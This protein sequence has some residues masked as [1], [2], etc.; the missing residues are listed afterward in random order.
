MISIP[1]YTKILALGSPYTE[2]ALI[3]DVIVQEKVDGSQ[4]KFGINENKEPVFASKGAKICPYIEENELTNIQKL[5]QPAVEYLLSI[6]NRFYNLL[7]DTYFYAETLYKPKHNVLEYKITPKNHIVLFDI[8]EQGR[9]VERKRLI[10]IAIMLDIDYI[11][12]L[13]RGSIETKRINTGNGGYKSS[14][15]D[16]LK[17]MIETTPSYLGNETIEG[18][19]IKN[20]NQTIMQGGNIYPLFTK[21]V[22][23]AFKERHDKEWKTKNPKNSLQDYFNSFKTEARWQKAVIH[24]KE[25]EELTDS[26]KDIGKIIKEIHKD[27]LEEEGDNIKN[28]LYKQFIDD[29]KRTSTRGLP[30]WYKEKLL[31]NLN[32]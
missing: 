13:Y 25:K 21:Y 14:A 26:P 16:F 11:P 31:E 6:Q 28:Y 27:I 8:L 22:R 24:L 5:F 10:E 9:W 1:S 20:Y 7:P 15:I 12:E 29:I 32:E 30:E 4:F 23:E 17:R 2:N 3:G 19:V 18:V